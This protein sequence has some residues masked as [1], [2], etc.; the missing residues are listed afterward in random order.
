MLGTLKKKVSLALFAFALFSCATSAWAGTVPAI[1]EQGDTTYPSC[2][3]GEI[4]YT[5]E[6]PGEGELFSL[7]CADPFTLT[8]SNTLGTYEV[9]FFDCFPTECGNLSGA[10][11]DLVEPTPATTTENTLLAE[12]SVYSVVFL[13]F[14]AGAF[15]LTVKFT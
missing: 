2:D 7:E 10:F 1:I 6:F 3:V 4:A 12:L 11:F 15:Y 13:A 14:F 8:T 5:V 9:K